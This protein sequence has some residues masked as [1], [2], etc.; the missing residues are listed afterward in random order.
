MTMIKIVALAAGAALLLSGS[1][2]RAAPAAQAIMEASC[3]GCHVRD[4]Q[5]H[6]SRI[7]EQRKTPEGWQM[8]LVRM[9]RVHG[10]RIVDP[11]G[12]DEA[13]ATRVLLQYLA[14]EQ[15]LA[16]EESGPW[17]YI[18]ERELN[19]IEEH[20]SAL[21]GEMCARCH[22]GARVA[23]QRRSEQEWRHLVHF[24]LGQ[25]P[26]VEYS[27]MGRDRDWLGI[28]L[29]EM[30]PYLS[31]HFALD[32]EAWRQWRQAPHTDLGG[33]WR[34]AGSMPGKGSFSGVMTASG[35]P[36]F[37]L[38]FQGQF[39]S[40]ETLVG[41]G[42][43]RVYNGHEWRA[44]L[45]L[46]E[47]R[48]KQVLAAN[49]EGDTLRGRMFLREREEWGLRLR[50]WRDDGAG[51][52]V[53]AVQP[54]FLQTGGEQQLRIVGTGLAPGAIDLG[55]G[56]EV[57]Q[58]LRRDDDTILL[59]VRADAGIAP[60]L[61]TVRIDGSDSDVAFTLFR[62][63]DRIAIEPAYA[64]A[65][66]GGNGGSQ[67]IVEAMFDAVGF[68]NGADG[69][70]DTADDLRIGVLPAQWSVAP[71]DAQAEADADVRFA[72]QMDHSSG[73]FTPAAAGPNP[74]RKYQTNNA[75]NLRVQAT[76][77][78]GDIPLEAEGQLIVTVQ[79]WN[80]PPIR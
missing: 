32:S 42:S 29:N 14:D 20:G 66:V 75:G 53:L 62:Q 68:S 59:R 56:I 13:A 49:A 10:A 24:H 36:P 39:D 72:G 41:E 55:E 76:L 16:P 19:T 31:E 25:F 70:P 28:A 54:A 37:R 50:A 30:V 46:N 18:L 1:P 34:V 71:F 26:S 40:G 5:G 47:Q 4:E 78:T 7:S 21:Y 6:W 2:L 60:A 69:E 64:V 43:A 73:V 22:S 80:N 35:E 11:A 15:G 38:Q 58:E 48:Y 12:G 61:R 74:E 65:R 51:P 52:R 9:Q 57:V 3:S 27:L 44:S 63:V 79:R 8:T 45:T 77:A 67:P 33:R 17:R 23:L